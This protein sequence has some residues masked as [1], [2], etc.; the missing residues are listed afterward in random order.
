MRGSGGAKLLLPPS[1]PLTRRDAQF[2]PQLVVGNVQLGGAYAGPARMAMFTAG[3]DEKTPLMA[4]NRQCSSG[5]QA[6]ANVAANIKMGG[7]DAGIGAGVE[8]MTSGGHPGDGPPPPIDMNAVF[9]NKLARDALTPMGITSENVAERYGI[10]REEQDKMAVAS[11]E[12]AL[13]VSLS[14]SLSLSLF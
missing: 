14:L 9:E 1:L 13:K 7:I 4:V 8:S 11:H 10:S 6:I 3:F 2:V 5:L 12:K